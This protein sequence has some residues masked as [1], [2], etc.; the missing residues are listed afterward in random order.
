RVPLCRPGR[1]GSRPYQSIG[2]PTEVVDATLIRPL[3]G[4]G[5]ELL[6]Q[7]VLANVSQLVLIFDAIADAMMRRFALP[8]PWL[9]QV[10]PTEP[11]FPEFDP[12]V[13]PEMQIVWS[14]K[15][16]HVIGHDE[17]VPDQPGGRFGAPDV[18]EAVLHMRA[19]RRDLAADLTVDAFTFGHEQ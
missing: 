11:A 5:D 1:R 19:R 10:T 15:E 7:G 12:L 18:C 3:V 8:R 13:D 4:S 9:L 2:C 6:A 17:V 14:A 16:M